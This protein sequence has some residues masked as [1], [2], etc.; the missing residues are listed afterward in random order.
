MNVLELLEDGRDNMALGF[1]TGEFARDKDD[2]PVDPTHA[3]ATCFCMSG[4]LGSNTDLFHGVEE[5]AERILLD[6]ING[7][8]LSRR[9]TSLTTYNDTPG[10]T[11]EEILQVFDDAIVRV[12]EGWSIDQ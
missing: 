11:Q 8:K 9:F 1:T 4:A 6:V 3:S 5:E 7:R 10:R 12:K 2:N